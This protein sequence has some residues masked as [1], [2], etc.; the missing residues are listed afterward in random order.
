MAIF[1]TRKDHAKP[2]HTAEEIKL[3][4]T[5]M[6]TPID[7]GEYFLPPLE[8]KGCHGFDTL[9][10]AFVDAAGHDVNLFD[11]WETSMMGLSAVDPLWRAKVSH[12]I[13][14]N[15]A[16][17]TDLQTFCTS[18]HA[19]MGHFTAIYKGFQHYT[20][21]DLY[22]D[23]LGLSGVACMSCH[24]L[25][26]VNQ[27]NVFSGQLTYDTTDISYGPFENPMMGP[28]QLYVGLT[29]RYSTHLN[30]GN[31]CSPCHTLISGTV[32][33]SGNPTGGTFVEQATFHEWLNSSFPAQEITCQ[34][35]HMPQLEDEVK[36]ATGYTAIPGRS[37]YNLHQFAGANSFMV[38]LMKN[39][40][41]S[42]G[43]TATDANFD[44]TLAAV[45]IMLRKNSLD[46]SAY[47]DTVMQDTA[48]I[49]ISLINKAGH[50][51]P[52]GYP[53]RRAVLQL[54]AITA[55]GDT[56]FSSGLFD[57]SY[58][59]KSLDPV[60]EKH[61]DVISDTGEVQVYE[62][63]MA[64]VNGDKTTLLE[65][66]ASH[67]K[68][69]RIP[70][71]GFTTLHNAYD[72]CHIVGDALT[73]TDFNKNGPVEGTGRDIVHYH[74]PLQN[75][76]GLLTIYASVYYQSVPPGWLTEMSAW[77][78]AEIDTFLQMYASADRSPVF[79]AGDTI[80]NLLI[81]TGIASPMASDGISLFPNPTLT[82]K[83]TLKANGHS[84]RSVAIYTAGGKVVSSFFVS[85]NLNT[86]EIHL[87]DKAGVYFVKI[88][89]SRGTF[90]KKVLRI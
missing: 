12:E 85:G 2:F 10:I 29:P 48:F 64:D 18:C 4:Q 84:V 28:M 3:F 30:R 16:H 82:G 77:S 86:F 36:I 49:S 22:S 40:K 20:L 47:T 57:A 35:C 75:Y 7:S 59:L 80:Q 74:I 83:T 60:F 62:M 11:D 24:S 43:I 88:I 1:P 38:K 37:P 26:S 17:D 23:T 46:V 14:T 19:P 65:R 42:L 41:S 9:G 52:T 50:K 32:D 58:E 13:L 51:F 34:T 21:A 53:A 81:S 61:Y 55:N 15:P 90:L 56:L 79:V 67:L 76:H 25:D 89:T 27:G 44:S 70:P 8:C 78:S 66:S 68:D 54:L 63:V 33:L 5:H 39:N 69:N 87:P 31:F 45:D 73:D 6:K 72:T 71:P